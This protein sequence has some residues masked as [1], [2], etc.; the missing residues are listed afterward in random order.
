MRHKE[1]YKYETCLCCGLEWNV[2][3][4]QVGWYVCPKCERTV[5]QFS[6]RGR[7]EAGTGREAVH[8]QD[9]EG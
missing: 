4:T 7:N 6:E 3:K 9:R 1:G 8:R 5:K 2:A